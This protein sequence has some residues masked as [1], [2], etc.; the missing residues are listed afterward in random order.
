M[1]RIGRV[2]GTQ[3]ATHSS[4]RATKAVWNAY[5][6]LYLVKERDLKLMKAD[7]L[8]RCIRALHLMKGNRGK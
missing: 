1:V 3:W 5:K 4:D 6:T 7:Q 8:H 2:L